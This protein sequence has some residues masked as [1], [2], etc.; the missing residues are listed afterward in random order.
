MVEITQLQKDQLKEIQLD[1]LKKFIN[2][3]EKLNLEYYI[4]AGTLIGA[5][6][7]KGFIP[8]DDDIDV[9]MKRKDYNVFIKR[10]QEFLPQEDYFVQTSASDP[11][12]PMNYCKLRNSKTTFVECSVKK[13]HINHGVYI[14]IFP[15]DYYPEDE[16]VAKQ[17]ERKKSY[18]EL[19]LKIFMWKL[20][21]L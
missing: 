1:L 7:H 9:A 15:L 11:E 17:Y 8:W 16:K 19:F 4:I 5:I 18:Q 3:C 2:A 20:K 14:D 10:A 21:R 6:R 12:W 13:L